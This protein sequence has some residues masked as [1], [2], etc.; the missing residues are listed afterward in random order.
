MAEEAT[1]KKTRR[2]V[3]KAETVRERAEKAAKK[4][5][6]TEPRRLQATQRKVSAPF[7]FIGRQFAKLGRI[8]LFRII[9]YIL[10]PPY[11]RNSWRELRKVTWLSFP[12][13][14][15]LTFAVFAFAFIFGLLIAFTDYGLDKLFKQVLLK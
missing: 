4:Q 7:R 3:K 12:M 9:G 14:L 11:F 2:P 6:S 8:K 10:K 5:N 13:S 1:S 15:R